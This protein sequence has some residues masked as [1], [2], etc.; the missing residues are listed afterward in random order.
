MSQPKSAKL[1]KATKAII[2]AAGLGTRFLPWT[3]AMPKEMLPLGKAPII[4]HII[5]G[6]VTAGV[7]QVAIVGGPQKRA[8]EN[9][10][11]PSVELEQALISR[12]K[13]A[14][15]KQLHNI[16]EMAHFVYIGQKGTPSGNARPLLNALESGF[17]SIKQPE[18]FFFMFADDF[19]NAKIS[20]ARQLRDVYQRTGKSVIS[21]IKV[22]P[23]AANIYGMA[24][25]GSKIDKDI[26]N[27]TDLA[28]KP[29]LRHRPSDY[30]TVSGYLLTPEIIPLVK[31]L[32]PSPR[33]EIE[34]PEAVGEL[35]KLGRVAGK[36]ID[37]EYHDA[38]NPASYAIAVIDYALKDKETRAKVT[39]YIENL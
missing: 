10:F 33:G 31:A 8:I 16:S 29:G 19:F 7:E 39:K 6:L 5:E 34:L 36:V 3:K 4:Q 14:E 28:E 9:H 22:E 30:A 1:P 27:V 24:K 23:A 2:A 32:K 11:D 15:A 18:P 21:L 25:L 13:T 35:A 38:G 37:G 26:F 12:G 17:I 20:Q